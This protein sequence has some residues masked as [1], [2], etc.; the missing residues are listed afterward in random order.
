VLLPLL[1]SDLFEV[2]LA[3]ARGGL[4]P[5]AWRR[6]AFAAA[7]VAAAPGYPQAYPKGAPLQVLS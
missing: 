1:E 4:G 2:M 6:D 3:C 5:V 7:V